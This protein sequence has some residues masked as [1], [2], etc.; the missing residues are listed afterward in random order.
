VDLTQATTVN[1]CAGRTARA[2]GPSTTRNGQISRYGDRNDNTVW[3]Q[4]D[5]RGWIERVI[6]GGNLATT[7]VG[8]TA[9]T[10]NYDPNG[11]LQQ[12]KDYPQQPGNSLDLPQRTVSYGYTSGLLTTV[13]MCGDTRRRTGTTRR[14]GSRR[15]PT[16]RPCY[17]VRVRRRIDERHEDDG[18]GWRVTEY[19]FVYDDNKKVFYSKIQGPVTASGRRTEDLT[20]DRAGDFLK[21]ELNG[22]TET[23]VKRDS[24]AR[25]ETRTNARGFAT[26]FTRNEF[27]QVVQVQNPDGTRTSPQFDALYLNPVEATD[28]AGFKTRYEYDGRGKPSQTYA[29]FWHRGS[30]HY[31]IWSGY[32]RTHYPYNAKRAC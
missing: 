8:Q 29:G 10:L 21:Y 28:E 6:D 5:S 20:H 31:G 3:I 14:S 30:A 27:E 19:N 17:S 11:R 2:T 7:T 32:C 9:L 18:C 16:K 25:T 26:I 13:A 4:R 23:E 12:V 22:R 1:G 15:S 24:A